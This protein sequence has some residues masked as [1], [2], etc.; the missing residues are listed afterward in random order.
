[1]YG[2]LV[3]ILGFV[4]VVNAALGAFEQ[5]LHRRWYRA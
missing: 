5:A 3:L 1:M 4:I 2:L